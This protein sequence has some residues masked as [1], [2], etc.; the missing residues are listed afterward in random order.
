MV[1]AAGGMLDVAAGTLL[2]ADNRENTAEGGHIGPAG[3][4]DKG[5]A[6]G[7]AAFHTDEERW[8]DLRLVAGNCKEALMAD[9]SPRRCWSWECGLEQAMTMATG[10][11]WCW[12]YIDSARCSARKPR[13]R[14]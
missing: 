5:T 3:M 6:P 2:E 13:R 8:V 7:R 9:R 4:V 1:E 10:C 11:W 14:H 12:C